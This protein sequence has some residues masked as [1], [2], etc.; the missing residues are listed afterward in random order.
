MKIGIIS[1]F[2]PQECGIGSEAE[3]HYKALLDVDGVEPV[4]ISS[5]PSADEYVDFSSP[6]F[7]REINRVVEDLDIDLIHL[8]H[9]SGLYSLYGFNFTQLNCPLITNLHEPKY[10]LPYHWYSIRSR[11]NNFV[12]KKLIDS[13]EKIIVHTEKDKSKLDKR[14]NNILHMPL[15]SNLKDTSS[16]ESLDTF[17]FFGFI[18]KQKNTLG[19]V[20]SADF[21]DKEIIIAGNARVEKD[22]DYTSKVK[23]EAEKRENVDTKIRWI[24]ENEKDELYREAD[25]ILLPYSQQNSGS[26]VL[27]DAISYG[28]PVVSSDAPI[29][30][31]EVKKNKIGVIAGTDPKEIAEGVKNLEEN[32]KQYKANISDYR[33]EKSWS[34][35]ARRYKKIYSQIIN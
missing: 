2:P 23:K 34:N 9:E 20:K 4:K 33:E 32:F 30:L 13:S 17:L 11:W 15:G 5:S 31:E 35:L 14:Y 27:S 10:N 7:Y 3:E 29:F 6:L 18:H 21:H 16:P 24:E 12:Q 8:H 1:T 26:G 19:A 22:E 25:A 28:R